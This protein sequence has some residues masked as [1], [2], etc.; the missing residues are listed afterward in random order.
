MS[1]TNALYTD[2]IAKRDAVIQELGEA[3]RNIATTAQQASQS[4][5]GDFCEWAYNTAS[6]ALG[7][8]ED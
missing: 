8:L 3:L 2:E 1:K 7:K 6:E 4:E 5:E